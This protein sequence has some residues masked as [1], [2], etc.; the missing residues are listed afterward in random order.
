MAIYFPDLEKMLVNQRCETE[1]SERKALYSNKTVDL[2]FH[3]FFS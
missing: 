3:L 1:I 2:K